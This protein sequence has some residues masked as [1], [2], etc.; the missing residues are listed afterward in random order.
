MA[1]PSAGR[2]TLSG[3]QPRAQTTCSTR[4]ERRCWPGRQSARLEMRC[5]LNGAFTTLLTCI[6][7]V[8]WWASVRHG[9]L[10]VD[11]SQSGN[12]SVGAPR[13]LPCLA[14]RS[15]SAGT[16]RCDEG[17]SSQRFYIEK[18]KCDQVQRG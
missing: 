17:A 7:R 15:R 3:G 4:C 14:L 16:M 6:K 5:E 12:V 1:P 8:K 11:R 10:V 9:R 18:R 13:A 2:L